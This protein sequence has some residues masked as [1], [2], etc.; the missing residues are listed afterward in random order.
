MAD[1]ARGLVSM[2]PVVTIAADS[3]AD[4][5]AAAESTIVVELVIDAIVVFA[6]IP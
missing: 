2:T 3:D 4:A 5:V 1:T 6:G